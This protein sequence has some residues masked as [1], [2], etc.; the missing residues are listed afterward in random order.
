M[1]RDGRRVA[2]APSRPPSRLPSTS[3]ACRSPAIP[4]TSRRRLRRR[5]AAHTAPCAIGTAMG[6]ASSR[7]GRRRWSRSSAR[8]GPATARDGHRLI[9]D[10]AGRGGRLLLLAARTADAP[11]QTRALIRFGDPI[12]DDVP[13]AVAEATRAGIQTMMV[14]GDHLDTA[15]RSPMPLACRRARRSPAAAADELTDAELPPHWPRMRLVARA[16]P[17]QK[18]RLVRVGQAAGRS[19]AVTGDGV[20]DAPALQRRRRRRGDGVGHGGGARGIGSR[21][22]RRLVRHHDGGTRAR[23]GGSLPTCRRASSSSSRPTWRCWASS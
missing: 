16:I 17:E 4:S 13:A 7:S 10:E 1:D 2:V 6:G 15:R 19:V 21:A 8:R 3:A 22:R 9:A 14:T 12:R 18:L 5:T 11:W 20:N 23:G